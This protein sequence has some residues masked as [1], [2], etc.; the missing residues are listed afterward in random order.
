MKHF[1]VHFDVVF[2]V[3]SLKCARMLGFLEKNIKVESNV[4]FSVVDSKMRKDASTLINRGLKIENV[5]LDVGFSV[6]LSKMRNDA[7]NLRNRGLKIENVE[8]DEGFS[9]VVSKIRKDVSL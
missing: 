7:S 1:F 2:H 4:L 5:E 8:L 9:V 3:G 6:V